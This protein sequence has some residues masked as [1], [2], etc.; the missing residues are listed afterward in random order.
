MNRTEVMRT[1]LTLACMA[2]IAVLG[3]FAMLA[4]DC[5]HFGEGS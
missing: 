4:A 1:S 3:A 2:L 5:L